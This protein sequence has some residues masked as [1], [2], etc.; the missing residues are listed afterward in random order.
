LAD[1]SVVHSRLLIAGIDEHVGVSLSRE[2][3]TPPP[4]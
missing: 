2:P 1:D 3:S 4:L